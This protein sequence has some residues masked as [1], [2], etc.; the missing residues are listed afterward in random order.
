M[1]TQPTTPQ[2]PNPVVIRVNE[3]GASLI[4]AVCSSA[5]KQAGIEAL[6][7]VNTILVNMRGIPVKQPEPPQNDKPKKEPEKKGN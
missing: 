3:Q 7:V 2:N 6:S 4:K 5:L 1:S